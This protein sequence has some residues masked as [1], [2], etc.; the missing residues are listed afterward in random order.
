MNIPN[1]KL[2]EPS[3]KPNFEPS[4]PMFV[5]K[6][7]FEPM[8]FPKN[9]TLLHRISKNVSTFHFVLEPD[10]FGITKT[11]HQTS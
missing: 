9:R 11:E 5:L 1:L 7:N 2:P 10:R 4:E 3:G 6:P 8:N